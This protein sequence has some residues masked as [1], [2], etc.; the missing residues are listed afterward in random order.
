MKK[1]YTLFTLLLATSLVFAQKAQIDLP[2]SW[3][4]TANVDYTTLGFGGSTGM[5]AADPNNASNP[6]LQIDKSNTAATWA[7]VTLGADSLA[8]AIPFSA[9]A[10]QIKAVVYSPDSGITV[11]LKAE[12]ESDPR[13]SVETDVMTTV[14][15]GWDTLTFDFS[16]QA[17][18]TAAINYST[19]YDKLSIFLNFGVDG[20]T[21]GA[22]TYYVDDVFFVSASGPSLSQ[23]DLPITWNDTANTDYTTVG[24]GG[25]VGMIAADPTNASNPVLQIDKSNTA[26]TWAGVTLGNDSLASAIPFASNANEIKVLFYSPDSGITV[27]LKVENEANSGISVETDAITMLANAWDTLTFDFSNQAQGT[28]AINYSNTYDQLNIF[29]NFGVDGATAGAK[30]YYVDDVFFVAPPMKS[31][32]DL[33]ISWNDTANTDYTTADFGGTVSMITADPANASNPVLQ[34]DKSNTA[35]TWAGVTLGNDSLASAIPFASNANLIKV[36]F[37]SPDAGITVRLKAEDESN[38]NIS[39]ETDAMTTVANAWDTLT[40]DFSN[41][42][43]GTAAI[44]YASTYD[45]LSIFPNF[46]VAGSTAGAKTYYVD[47]V[48]FSAGG[49]GNPPSTSMITFKVDMNDYSSNFDTV[50]VGGSFNGYCAKCNPMS[51]NDND[52]VWEL[53]IPL[54]HDTIEWKYQV[55]GWAGEE[56]FLGGEPCTKTTGA[57]TNRYLEHNKDTVMPVTCWSTCAPCTGVPTTV[58][59]KFALDLSA[60]PDTFSNAYVSGTFNGWSPDANPLSDSD[61]DDVWETTIALAYGDTIEFKYQLNKW[62]VEETLMV[63]LPCTKTS[64]AFTNRYL[65]LTADTNLPVAC[66][67]ECVSCATIGFDESFTTRKFEVMPNPSN[68]VFKVNVELDRVEDVQLNVYSIS[69]QKVFELSENTSRLTEEIDLGN[70]NG[71]IYFLELRKA[72]TSILKKLVLSK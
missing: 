8:S 68:G 27:R 46:N 40:F 4:D 25:S 65:E 26:Q 21:A 30:T 6:V 20:A 54:N 10:N 29:A 70:L 43:Q 36:L 5:I 2:I 35:Q 31:Q 24:F 18:G 53:T 58:N 22:K 42:A 13:K 47:D 51:D 55:D 23:I 52:G 3:N 15:N 12:D 34:I 19:T 56:R 66:W 45:K 71:G 9:T 61:N 69:G 17:Q 38:P 11:R 14:A 64:G 67:E 57:F 7:G 1:I 62:A 60:Y 39:V 37:Y 44:N 41:Q 50:Y 63:G 48:F 32:I 33:P 59:V 72:E 16:N 28:A 49:G